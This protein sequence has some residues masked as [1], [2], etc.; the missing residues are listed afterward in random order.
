MPPPRL[1]QL[2]L[3]RACQLGGLAL[4]SLTSIL[5]LLGWHREQLVPSTPAATLSSQT[6]SALTDG[7]FTFQFNRSAYEA[8]FPHLQLYQC[9]E[10]IA[11]D[12]FCQGPS[13]APLLLLA[14]KSHP[15]SSG[16]RATLRRTWAQPAELGGFRLR[17]LFLLGATSN[18]KHLEL[19]A[20]E[21]RVFGDIL[22]WDFMECHHNLSL[23]ERCFLRWVHGHCQQAAFVFKGDDDLFVN[24]K[25]LTDYLHRTPNVSH[26][27]HGNIQ[28]H[29]TVMR[30]GK[31]A[32]SRDFYPLDHYPN[33]ASGGGFIMSRVGLAALYRASLQLPVFPLDDVYLAFLTLAAKI[34]HRHDGAFRVWGIPKDELSAYRRSVCIHGVSME[35]IEEVWK[36]LERTPEDPQTPS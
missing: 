19:V 27:I 6:I 10:V 7:S 14:I 34:P 26:F 25:V 1:P 35:R 3:R 11:R 21:S 32:I 36:E 13:G 18:Q 9:Q 24:P 15:A 17:P 22:R 29:P 8:H 23:K 33:F 2:T 20:Q 31:Y 28:V 16:R 5:L 4:G 12:D 30:G